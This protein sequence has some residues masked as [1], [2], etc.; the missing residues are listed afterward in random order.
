VIRSVAPESTVF[1]LD[2]A[3][4]MLEIAV[5]RERLPCALGDAMALPIATRSVDA[6][7]LAYVLFHL[8]RPGAAL[9]EAVRVLRPGGQ[10]G[11][12]TWAG[13]VG[14][15]AASVVDAALEGS[16]APP[17]PWSGDHGGLDSPPA[18]AELLESVGLLPSAVWTVALEHQFTLD[19]FWQLQVSGGNSG[20]RLRQLEPA[21][22]TAVV[23]RIRGQLEGLG[24][25]QFRFHGEVVLA[26]A[27]WA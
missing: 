13:E 9:R 15:A 21:Q 14:A 24:P 17:A 26:V 1:G 20:W 25:E 6:V 19:G 4:G 2:L 11:T 10:V 22:R 16:G 5:R 18:V 8:R 23:E 27:A 12:L 7:V 3:R